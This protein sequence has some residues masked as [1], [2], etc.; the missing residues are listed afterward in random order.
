[1]IKSK[2]KNIHTEVGNQRMCDTGGAARDDPFLN[3]DYSLAANQA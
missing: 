3:A 1:V 2:S